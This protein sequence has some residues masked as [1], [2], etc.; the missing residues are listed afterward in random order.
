MNKVKAKKGVTLDSLAVMVAGGFNDV[1]E[2]LDKVEGRLDKVEA[3][4]VTKDF[5]EEKLLALKGDL[6]VMMRKEDVKLKTLIEVLENKKILS[7][8]EAGK[9]LE[10]EP[11]PRS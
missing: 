2:R 5:L 10:M 4:M 9:I 6:T 7:K 8:S 11:F 1:S 3:K